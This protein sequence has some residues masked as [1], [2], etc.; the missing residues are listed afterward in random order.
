MSYCAQYLILTIIL[1]LAS[2]IPSFAEENVGI[3]ADKMEYLLETRQYSAKGSV[4]ITYEDTTL[5]GDE[6]TYDSTSDIAIVTGNVILEDSETLVTADKLEINLRTKKGVVQNSYIFYKENNIHVKGNEIRKTGKSSFHLD[7]ATVTTCDANPPEWHISARDIN[8][9]QRERVKGRS[10]KF[11]IKNVPV[12]YTPYFWA[13]LTK[14]RETGLLFPTFGYSSERGNYY[15]Q[16]FFWA[17]QENQD[18]TLYLDYYG[19]KGLAQGLDYRYV[20]SPEI[21]GELWLYNLRDDSPQRNLNEIKYYHNHKFTRDISGYMK[22]HKVSHFDYYDTMGST[23]LNR[24]GLSSWSNDPFGLA[25]DEKLQKYLESNIQVS[26][27]FFG[28][29]AYLLAQGRQSLEESSRTIP[30]SLPEL[31]FILNTRSKKHFSFNMA[32]KGTNFV[33][34]EGQDGFRFDINPNIYFSYGRLLNITQRIGLR[35]T[36]YFLA[37]PA[38][39]EARLIFD[40]STA[41]TTKFYKQ[42]ASFIHMI[43]PSLEYLHIPGVNQ[44]DIPFFDSLDFIPK[45]SR[46]WREISLRSWRRL[47]SMMIILT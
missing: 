24:V 22:I 31:A 28:G 3:T 15:K 6:A 26:K 5:R 1:I 38:K 40:S 32:V 2:T 47:Y 44:D 37:S 23:S 42:Y 7:E 45:T 17:I 16:G 9:A 25:S 36:S 41:L 19:E 10:G 39:N 33:R 4:V 21:N 46:K 18:A 20:L 14:E 8:L 13:P 12:L 35:E 11:H 34:D 29:R 43:E 30:Q 27:S